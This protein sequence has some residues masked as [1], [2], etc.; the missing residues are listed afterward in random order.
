MYWKMSIDLS[1]PLVPSMGL[2]DPL[3]GLV[4]FRQLVVTARHDFAGP[5]DGLSD[6]I[7]DLEQMCRGQNWLTTDP[8]G[9]GGLLHDASRMVQLMARKGAGE[10]GVLDA[11][12]NA[13]LS[14]LESAQEGRYS[15][16]PAEHRLAFRELGLSVGLRAVKRLPA[17]YEKAP[18]SGMK[19]L[20]KKID[21]LLN[22]MSLA[23]TIE[24][25]WSNQKN[26]E[27]ASWHEHREINT[28]MLATSLAP[29]GFVAI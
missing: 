5:S 7:A 29:E 13:A 22:H 18:V 11:V 16:Q 15:S 14:G 25:F 26:R 24:G 9:I 12:M 19:G 17:F 23:Q 8:L 21:A 1:R 10:N 27:G 3:D 20:Q 28:V 2:Q 6:Q 4:T